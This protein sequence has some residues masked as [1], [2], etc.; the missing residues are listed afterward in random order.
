LLCFLGVL[1]SGMWQGIVGVG[2]RGWGEG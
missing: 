2:G 1:V